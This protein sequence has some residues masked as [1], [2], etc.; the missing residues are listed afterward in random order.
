MPSHGYPAVVPGDGTVYG[1]VF[2]F[3]DF[4]KA[5]H[6]MDDLEDYYGPGEDNVYERVITTARLQDGT[7]VECYVYVFPSTREEWLRTEA[8]FV[9]GGDWVQY[10]ESRAIR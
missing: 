3:S 5:L 2:E 10:I 6:A 7:A 1:E 8:E 4:P 9:P